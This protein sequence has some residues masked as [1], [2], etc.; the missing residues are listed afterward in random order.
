MSTILAWL[1]SKNWTAHTVAVLA[2]S[3]ATLISSDQMVRD[4]VL[5]LFKAHPA[6]GTD[7]VAL[8]AIILKYSR[9]SSPAGV[10]ALSQNI[11]AGPDAPS[12]A[13]VDAADIQTK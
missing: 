12:K 13:A 9:S 3:I 2:V 1:K 10:V 5:G 4:F 8:A 7:I 6:I 11:Q